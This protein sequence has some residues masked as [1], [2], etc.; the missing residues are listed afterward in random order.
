MRT[1]RRALAQ[2]FD[3]PIACFGDRTSGSIYS[4]NNRHLQQ[5]N[6]P[7]DAGLAGETPALE[8]IFWRCLT[9]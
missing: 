4:N 6:H 3:R 2:L 1:I 7:P 9:N 5:T 8:F